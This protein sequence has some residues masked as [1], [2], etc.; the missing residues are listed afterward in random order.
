[1]DHIVP[2]IAKALV[3]DG[4]L[5]TAESSGPSRMGCFWKYETCFGAQ[6][7]EEE[8]PNVVL[9]VYDFP[10]GRPLDLQVQLG[11]Q[12]ADSPAKDCAPVVMQEFL[13]ST[14][15][16]RDFGK[17][18]TEDRGPSYYMLCNDE[19]LGFGDDGSPDGDLKIRRQYVAFQLVL[20]SAPG[21]I[22]IEF[23]GLRPDHNRV[24]K[25]YFYPGS[26]AVA[27]VMVYE[28]EDPCVGARV[29]VPV[30]GVEAELAEQLAG[31]LQAIYDRS[32]DS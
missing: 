22:F 29:L 10:E 31:L 19:E 17:C 16:P 6:E 21:G 7:E 32:R 24:A 23:G 2:A 18:V 25:C 9:E 12:L 4:E 20:F 15:T 11:T 26:K 3:G 5:A 27:P 13:E 14:L 30:A 1:M 8:E 28:V